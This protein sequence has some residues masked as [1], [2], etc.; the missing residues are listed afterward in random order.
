MDKPDTKTMIS[1]MQAFDAGKQIEFKANGNDNWIQTTYPN[2][3][4][5]RCNYRVKE[6]IKDS[7]NFAGLDP[8]WKYAARDKNDNIYVYQNEPKI[9]HRCECWS[10]TSSH[11]RCK[12]IT[13]LFE[14]YKVGDVDWNESLIERR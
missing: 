12:S 1:V 2:W 8:K 11:S 4:W 9:D 14:T 7:F 6:T 13:D 5:P 3:D 10:N